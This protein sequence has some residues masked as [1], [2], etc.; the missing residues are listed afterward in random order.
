MT[1]DLLLRPSWSAGE[2]ISMAT[3]AEDDLMARFVMDTRYARNLCENWRK[4]KLRHYES[5][6]KSLQETNRKQQEIIGETIAG[7]KASK[8]VSLMGVRAHTERET[9]FERAW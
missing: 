7:C 9:D 3:A 5:G 8:S 4:P 1:V 6:Q 2:G